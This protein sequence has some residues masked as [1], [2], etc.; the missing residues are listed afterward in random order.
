MGI[1]KRLLVSNLIIISF[2]LIFFFAFSTYFI[3]TQAIEN[4]EKQ[5]I[6]E[7]NIRA[8]PLTDTAQIIIQNTLVDKDYEG[9]RNERAFV[10]HNVNMH[11]SN[12]T[13]NMV[14]EVVDSTVDV[15]YINFNPNEFILDDYVLNQIR[16]M[17]TDTAEIL[18]VQD[19]SYLAIS[20]QLAPDTDFMLVSMIAYHEV[21]TITTENVIVFV[22]LLSVL[23]S[24]SFMLIHYQSR[25]IT[26]PI[27]KL[28]QVTKHY[29]NRDFSINIEINTNDEIQELSESIHEMVES[30]ISYERSQVALFRNLSHELKTPLTA[31]SGYAEGI[32]NGYYS[33]IK[34]PLK[35]IQ[36]E[37]TR[38]KNIL[39]DL[40]F[41]SKINSKT[42][43]YK[44]EEAD[45]VDILT[46]AV[47]KLES[48]AILNDID[49]YYE[50][51]APIIAKVDKIKLLRMFIN[52]ISN[53]LK[54]TTDMI[55]I[56]IVKKQADIE[57][58]ITDNGPGF[59]PEALKNLCDNKTTEA[60]NGN[61]LGLIIV[62]E[63]LKQHCGNLKLGNTSTS[64]AYVTIILSV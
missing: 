4:M 32:E 28:S 50:P 15:I 38:I 58:T 14:Y 49:I 22:A 1:Y 17:K 23:L 5:L 59:K 29:A 7:N 64:G 63:I 18:Q 21:S 36:E 55:E 8:K 26:I 57:I 25:K 2:A 20:T 3:N 47:I 6:N 54:H 39:E 9:A 35:I 62:K 31:I 11:S 44:F 51:I 60:I 16:D 56:T 37:S 40:I 42:E 53:A 10:Q 43:H 46:S 19:E 12:N 61:G 48:I 45:I 52:I 24:I 13:I 33:D 41:L 30:L 34:A 27:E